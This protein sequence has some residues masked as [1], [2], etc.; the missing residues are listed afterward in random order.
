MSNTLEERALL[1]NTSEWL[2]RTP[3]ILRAH[4]HGQSRETLDRRP[5][6][7]AWSQTEILAHLAD[8]EVVCFQTRVE[9]ILGGEPIRSLNADE[10]AAEIPYAAINTL[11][12]L[13]VFERERERS[14]ARLRQLSPDQLVR[15]AVHG[16]LGEMSLGRLLTEWVKHDLSHIRQL[17]M[18]A[19][20]VFLPGTE[21]GEADGAPAQIL[22]SR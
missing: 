10:R 1:E 15:W 5:R 4:V 2:A 22:A 19:G 18:T 9:Q 8:F 12:S 7:D 13:E 14:L 6:A 16:E 11:T 20:Q 21:A 17:V 3:G